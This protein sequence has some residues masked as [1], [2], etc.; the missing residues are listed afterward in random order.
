MDS[1]SL[2]QACT[3]LEN[4]VTNI[5]LFND[6]GALGLQYANFQEEKQFLNT[7]LGVTRDS[8]IAVSRSIS[9][10]KH[11]FTLGDAINADIIARNFMQEEL[12]RTRE[13]YLHSLTLGGRA[14]GSS[15]GYEHYPSRISVAAFVGR[16][17]FY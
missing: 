7:T 10:A 2:L 3:H 17:V 14:E 5:E 12:A 4:T 6:R 1:L 11:S 13:L 15:E 8:L 9:R 16:I